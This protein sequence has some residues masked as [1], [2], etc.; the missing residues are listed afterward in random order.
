MALGSWGLLLSFQFSSDISWIEGTL[1]VRRWV[2]CAALRSAL[3]FMVLAVQ[4]S[5]V[6]RP[7]EVPADIGSVAPLIGVFVPFL[8]K[9]FLSF[10]LFSVGEKTSS[11]V[12]SRA[13]KF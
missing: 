7:A 5:R 13:S 3:A 2:A 4:E 9:G 1:G 12:P 8:E 10:D 11:V 6:A